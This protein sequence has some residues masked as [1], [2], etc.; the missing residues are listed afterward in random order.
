MLPS[1]AHAEIQKSGPEEWP[2]KVM[3]GV[4]PLGMQLQFNQ[5]WTVNTNLLYTYGI[6]DYFLY[7]AAID[8]AGIIASPGKVTIWLG[9]EINFGGRGHLALA[10]PGL[11]VQLTLEKL[12]KI[13]LVPMIRLGF[14]GDAYV[15]YGF[16]GATASGAILFK[17]GA[18]IYYFVTKHVGLGVDTDFAFGAGLTKQFNSG[19]LNT[20]F[21][22]YWDLVLGARFAL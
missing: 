8:V 3:I 16:N 19:N 13:P 6:T 20:G 12:L 22:G 7:K 15:P 4:R 9:G 1:L 17:L 11:F 5:A 2:G 14:V 21:T 10:E 18:G